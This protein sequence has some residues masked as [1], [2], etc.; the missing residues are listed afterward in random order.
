MC[1]FVLVRVDPVVFNVFLPFAEMYM[2][3]FPPLVVKGVYHYWTYKCVFFFIPQQLKAWVSAQ[4][5]CGVVRGGPELK[6][7]EGSTKVPPGFQQDST[8][9]CEGCGV[10]RTLKRAPYSVGDIT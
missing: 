5:G 8:R 4:I 6:F 9:F 7:H 1:C 2:F 10:V 3:Y